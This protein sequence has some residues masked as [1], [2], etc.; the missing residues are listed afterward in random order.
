MG[1]DRVSALLE[2]MCKAQG[3]E[4][5]SSVEEGE[6]SESPLHIPDSPSPGDVD[7]CDK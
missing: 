3:I 5:S 7:S 4:M 2:A 6:G 1:I